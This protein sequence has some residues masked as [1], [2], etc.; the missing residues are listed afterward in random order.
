MSIVASHNGGSCIQ[1]R[2]IP[3][4]TLTAQCEE[5]LKFYEQC[6]GGKTTFLMTWEGSLM[7]NQAPPG[8]AKK[9]L[10]AILTLDVGVLEGCD[11]MPGQ[12]KNP[13]SFCLMFRPK[14][15]NEAERIFGALAKDGKVEIPIMETFWALRFGKVVDRNGIPWLIDCDKPAA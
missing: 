7:A 6:L 3:I 15:A 1:G 13:Q 5:A 9:I 14:D 4:F 2:S 12:Y 8:W 10:H 11:A